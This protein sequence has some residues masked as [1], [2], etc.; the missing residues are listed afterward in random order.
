MSMDELFAKSSF[1][2]GALYRRLEKK[3]S[4]SGYAS[5]NDVQRNLYLAFRFDAEV[6]MGGFAG[7][8]RSDAA[9]HAGALLSALNAAGATPFADLA[10]QALSVFPAKRPADDEAARKKQLA[11]ITKSASDKW[12]ALDASYKQLPDISRAHLD[13]YARAH[14]AD[15]GGL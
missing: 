9:N 5:L 7:Y 12:S 1:L 15:F 11:A 2:V 8:F 3:L 10:T 14:Q 13:A 4:A 6:K